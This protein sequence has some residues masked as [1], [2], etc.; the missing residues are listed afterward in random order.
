MASES[1]SLDML[2]QIGIRS[3]QTVLD[4]GCGL[5]IYT[6]PVAKIVGEQGRV[7]AL[8]KDKEAVDQLVQK[9]ESEGLKNI[10]RM[11]TPRELGID[12]ADECVDA[13]LLFDVFHSFY[14]PQAGDRKRLLNEIHRIMKPSAFLSISIWPNLMEPGAEDE[15]KDA[16]FRL[17]KDISQTFSYANKNVGTRSVLNFRKRSPKYILT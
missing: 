4:F 7:Y 9:A 14:F 16:D 2:Q 1:Q 15:I 13:V 17:E 10:K 6:I 5:G 3:G 8:D 11:E 12:L